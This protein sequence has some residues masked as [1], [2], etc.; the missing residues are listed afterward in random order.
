MVHRTLGCHASFVLPASDQNWE[1]EDVMFLT[2]RGNRLANET[3]EYHVPSD[4]P[5]PNPRSPIDIRARYIRQKYETRAFKR[6][7]ERTRRAPPVVSDVVDPDIPDM[8]V[9]FPDPEN[10]LAVA[11]T[12]Q[13]SPNLMNM[14]MGMGAHPRFAGLLLVRVLDASGV[15]PPAHTHKRPEMFCKVAVGTEWSVSGRQKWTGGK[16]EIQE[17]L[18]VS[19]DGF[20][21]LRLS[22][23]GVLATVGVT[24]GGHCRD[25]EI[26]HVFISV[27]SDVLEGT[28]PQSFTVPLFTTSTLLPHQATSS[29]Q[30]ATHYLGSRQGV[31]PPRFRPLPH[32]Q[33]GC[34]REVLQGVTNVGDM[35]FGACLA[36]SPIEC[37]LNHNAPDTTSVN[38]DDQE[39]QL[40]SEGEGN[41]SQSVTDIST[42]GTL[43]TAHHNEDGHEMH[44]GHTLDSNTITNTEDQL[45]CETQED[46]KDMGI[47]NDKGDSNEVGDGKENVSCPMLKKSDAGDGISG[48]AR[49]LA[50]LLCDNAGEVLSSER[51][52]ALTYGISAIG[53]KPLDGVLA[54]A[55]KA[56]DE[57]DAQAGALVFAGDVTMEI[58]Y[59]PLPH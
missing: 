25:D 59:Q 42:M 40:N 34:M 35:V 11:T 31:P 53:L 26:G 58:M 51:E 22:L 14:H 54:Y 6:T 41:T 17:G 16:M 19:W 7:S 52:A 8:N 27:D 46:D 13:P 1:Y 24:P 4:C 57:F 5:K 45:K 29:V 15:L 47:A 36:P 3:L 43:P 38:N 50:A 28:A 56:V 32:T 2:T 9:S 30:G 10:A 44:T 49:A 48:P 21:P 33:S 20:S 37:P 55:T 23:R 39:K 12:T 18:D